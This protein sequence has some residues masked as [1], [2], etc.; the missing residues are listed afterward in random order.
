MLDAIFSVEG[1]AALAAL[2]AMEI[3]LGIDNVVF[4]AVLVSRLSPEQGE[5]VRRLG[6]MLALCMRIVLIFALTTLLT[7][8]EP[9]FSV[10]GYA[11]S[12]RDILLI[13]GGIF[14]IV[15][16]THEM[17]IEAEGAGHLDDARAK[18]GS[19]A[20]AIFQIIVIDLV[21]S[22]DST[23]TAIGMARDPS[24][25]A[26]A[27]TVAMVVMYLAAGVVAAFVRRHPSTKFLA[28]AFLIL[29]GVALVA[30]GVHEPIDRRIIYIA[31]AFT[32]L[33]EALNMRAARRRRL[34]QGGDSDV[35]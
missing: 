22:I 8:T 13:A 30:E 20:G 33:V 14:L 21:F 12:W 16:A 9:V 1:M 34:R 24:L 11:V 35:T 28:L 29:I 6:L 10:F 19:L 32:V 17:H 5:F 18:P 3:V 23:V 26:I 15:K 27:I 4:L 31:M 7:L 25:M 2:T